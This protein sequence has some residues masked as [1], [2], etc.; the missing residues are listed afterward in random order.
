MLSFLRPSPT[1]TNQ[2]VQRSIR[3]MIWE[4]VASGA[5]FSLGSGGFVAAY[6][7]A[8]GANNLQVGILAALPFI[9]QVAQLPAILAVERFRMRKAIGVPA[10]CAAQLLWIPIG[11][12]PFLLETPGAPA[13]AAVIGLMAVRGLFAPV[14]ATAWTSWMRDLVPRNVLASYYGRRLAIITGVIA[15]VGLGGSFFVRWW[16]SASAP[17]DAILAY[18]FL[19]IGGALTFGLLSPFVTLRAREPLMPAA[20]ELGRSALA[21][22]SSVHSARW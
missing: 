8:L 18:S 2:E 3:L 12:V 13:V 11:A 1:L 17:E 7:L 6:A 19:L 14:W 10:I 5:M 16:E 4:G 21:G 9:T 20:P 15:A 22:L